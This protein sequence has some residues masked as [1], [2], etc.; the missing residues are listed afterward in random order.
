[1]SVVKKERKMNL[2]TMAR[3]RSRSGNTDF[4]VLVK[5][6]EEIQFD[7]KE[8]CVPVMVEL[9][10]QGAEVPTKRM[11]GAACYDLKSLNYHTIPPHR[12]SI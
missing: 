10:R 1:M 5:P 4:T 6:L 8:I 12:S 11:P 7:N 2:C 3:R 9:R